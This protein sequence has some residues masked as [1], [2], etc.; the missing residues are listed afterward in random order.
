MLFSLQMLFSQ[1]QSTCTSSESSGIHV[2]TNQN[3]K[4][5]SGMETRLHPQGLFMTRSM[6]DFVIMPLRPIG[7]PYN[8][9]RNGRS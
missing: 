4:T 3:L 5:K 2:S 1:D 8:F 9:A 6:Y 7:T